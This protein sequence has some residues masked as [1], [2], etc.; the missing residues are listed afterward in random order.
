MNPIGEDEKTPQPEAFDAANF[1]TDALELVD[2]I[3]GGKEQLNAEINKKLKRQADIEEM[4]RIK[5]LSKAKARAAAEKFKA[6]TQKMMSTMMK[7]QEKA[8]K[9]AEAGEI[10]AILWKINLYCER[11]PGV[12]SRIPKLGPKPSIGECQEVLAI[13]KDIMMTQG[14]MS[15]IATYFNSGFTILETLWGDGTKMTSVPPPLRF[16]LAGISQLFR[17][18]KFPELEPLI[19]EMDI[20]Y[21]WLGRRPLWMR[22]TSTIADILTRVHIYNTNPAARKLFD[23]EAQQP[24]KVDEDALN[25]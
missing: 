25:L 10:K 3:E 21:P 16:N 2:E 8:Q 20:E 4:D 24:V 11:F 19:A 17:Q 5:A 22:F 14:S 13:I 15:S 7:A 12:A 9:E 1:T 6:P 18:G 23:M